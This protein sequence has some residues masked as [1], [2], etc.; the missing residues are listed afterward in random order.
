MN[1]FI[2]FIKKELFLAGL[3]KEEY[4]LIQND[5]QEENRRSLL[6]FS[7]ITIVFL[8]IMFLISFFSEDV[9]AN[10]WVYLFAM[11]ITATMSV[12]AYLN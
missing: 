7:A 12:V 1:R 8:L 2:D 9:E 5:L 11:L 10:R 4:K 3:S 6:A